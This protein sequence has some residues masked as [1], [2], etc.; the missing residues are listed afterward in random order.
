MP[1]LAQRGGQLGIALRAPAKLAVELGDALA[2]GLDQRQ[3]ARAFASAERRKR[4][5]LDPMLARQP[6]NVEQARLGLPRAG[7]D[8]RP[9][10]RR[11]ER[12]CPR[13][14]SPRSPPGRAPPA[15]RPA[16][17]GRPRRARSAAP[18]GAAAPAR[19]PIRRAVRRG[20]SAT[21]AGLDSGLHRRALLGEARLLARLRR[22]RLDLRRRACSSQSRSRSA[23]ASCAARLAQFRLDPG[24]LAPRPRSTAPRVDPAE[25]VE[26]ARDGRG[27]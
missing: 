15:L 24:D 19:R 9:A 1:L 20:R 2:A 6:A 3:A 4:I 8:R 23:A 11:R 5:G 16:T 17:D 14:R 27:D 13:P 22:Q 26:Q 12:S 7:P 21:L 25:R 18:P 10:P